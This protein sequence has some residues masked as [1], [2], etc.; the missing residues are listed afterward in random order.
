MQSGLDC[1]A[2]YFLG[3]SAMTSQQLLVFFIIHPICLLL[4]SAKMVI[5]TFIFALQRMENA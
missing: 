5:I 1:L 2:I 3:I 4:L